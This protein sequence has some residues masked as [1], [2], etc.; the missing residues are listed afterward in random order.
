MTDTSP[1][2]IYHRQ[3]QLN[4]ISKDNIYKFKLKW[5]IKWTLG[6]INLELDATKVTGDP[7]GI[8]L[9]ARQL[10]PESL[11]TLGGP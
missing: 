2:V 9:G 3:F 11:A 7:L 4:I 8:G 10:D 6:V 5:Y 1:L